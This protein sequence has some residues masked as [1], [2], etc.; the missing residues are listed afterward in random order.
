MADIT[1]RDGCLERAGRDDG[2]TKVT[3]KWPLDR[4][5]YSICKEWI[6]QVF[7]PDFYGSFCK[8]ASV[9]STFTILKLV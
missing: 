7:T 5:M 4:Q 9:A 3:F 6:S 8:A 1:E 2:D